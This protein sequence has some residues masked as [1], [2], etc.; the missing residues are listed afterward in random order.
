MG[1]NLTTSFALAGLAAPSGILGTDAVHADTEHT[2][3]LSG[4]ALATKEGQAPRLPLPFFIPVPKT[5]S[6]P[7]A[8]RRNKHAL[9]CAL[10]FLF[11]DI[12]KPKRGVLVTP[13]SSMTWRNKE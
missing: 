11:L 2:L 6:G 12:R 7:V 5:Q 3:S 13:P 1:L 8:K 10:S 9:A 4:T